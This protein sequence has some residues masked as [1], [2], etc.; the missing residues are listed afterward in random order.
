MHRCIEEKKRQKKLLKT[1]ALKAWHG[2][3]YYYKHRNKI[4]F[5]GE[6]GMTNLKLLKSDAIFTAVDEKPFPGGILVSGQRIEKVFRKEELPAE[7]E[8]NW[9]VYDYGERLIMPG[10]IDGHVHFSWGATA[11]S[12]HMC[13]DIEHSRSEAECASMMETFAKEHPEEKR[14]LG[15]GWFPANWNDAPLPTKASLDA[16]IPD[17]PV[18]LISADAH[19]A[20]LNTKALEE[21]NYNRDSQVSFGEICKDAAGEPNG[22]LLEL[23]AMAPVV[24]KMISFEHDVARDMYEGFLAEIRSYGITSISDMTAHELNMDV[25]NFFNL[26]KELEAEGRLSVRLHVYSDLLREPSLDREKEMKK[27]FSSEKM[28]YA[29]LKQ[30]ID[31]VTSTYTAFLL[32]P[33][34]DKPE[35]NGFSNYPKEV[36]QEAVN[37]ANAEGFGVRLHCIGDKAVRWALDIFEESNRVNDN[38]G[39]K[40]GLKNSI[41]HIESLHPEDIPRFDKLGVIASMQPAHLPLDAN[42]KLTRIGKERCVY[43]WPFKSMCDSNAQLAFGTDFPVVGLNPFPNLYAAIT[44]CGSDGLPTGINPE[45]TISLQQALCAY[46][47]GSAAVYGREEELGSL[48]E[49]KLADI[50]VADRNLFTCTPQEI[51]EGKIHMTMFDGEIVYERK[52]E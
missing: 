40:R 5:G 1:G 32:E 18:Y 43:E 51:K 52:D 25:L 22:M 24:T 29:G 38:E 47:I 33:Y 46:T 44:R 50:I 48:E 7:A 23:E 6:G 2:N 31:G 39:N 12:S 41:E 35:T 13:T 8:K 3:C 10:F 28:R 49:G 45:E 9:R 34:A 14:I 17:R 37:R 11:A 21:C 15:I 4:K 42:E 26:M 19:S 16:V 30:F 20:W 36:Y 27:Q